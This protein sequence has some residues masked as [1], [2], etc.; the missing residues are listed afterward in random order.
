MN[1]RDG[2][3]KIR[4]LEVDK[5]EVIP[6]KDVGHELMVN[7]RGVNYED[8]LEFIFAKDGFKHLFPLVTS[9]MA[10]DLVLNF[11]EEFKEA[12]KTIEDTRNRLMKGK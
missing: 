1:D 5:V 3:L 6:D 8:M 12:I 11:E 10:Y 4:C 7:L 9:D 2:W